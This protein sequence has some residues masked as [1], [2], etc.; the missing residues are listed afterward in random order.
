MTIEL[1]LISFGKNWN[2]R[3][4]LK[5]ANKVSDQ[6]SNKYFD[7]RPRG[8]QIGA[9]ASY[10]SEQLSSRSELEGRV[11]EFEEK[12]ADSA[13]PQTASLGDMS[14]FLIITNSGRVRK[15]RLHDRMVY[16]GCGWMD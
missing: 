11:R 3:F 7:D 16:Q 6:I 1:R 14:S 10:Q 4:V 15:G 12:F 5:D 9:W 2:S 13:V 8:S